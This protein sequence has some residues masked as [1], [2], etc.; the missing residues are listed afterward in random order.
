MITTTPRPLKILKQILE[1][2]NTAKST[3]S[4]YD[5]L[6]NLS[7]RFVQY[8]LSR[9][10]GTRLGRQEIHAEILEDNP[11]AIFKRECLDR[12]RILP[13]DLP[14]LEMVTIPVDPAAASGE[15]SDDT[16]IVPVGK[17]WIDGLEHFYILDDHTCHLPPGGWGKEALKALHIHDGDRIVGEVNNGG[18]MVEHVIR[19]CQVRVKNKA[20]GEMEILHG[21][22]VGYK[23]VHASRGKKV[24]AE[25]VAALSEQGRLH[26]VGT[27]PEL[28]DE[29]CEWMPGD[30]SPD[31]M[32]SMVWGVI[33]MLTHGVRIYAG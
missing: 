28:E 14:D 12:D 9:Y 2:S 6:R 1:D 23:S 29:I 17:A 8:V 10:E 21:R 15:A 3:G 19:T 7:P 11:D 25:P 33:S 4:T 26:I 18:E 30:P 31:R 16:G 24:R 13:Q 20:T 22:N 32:D 27:L 5:N